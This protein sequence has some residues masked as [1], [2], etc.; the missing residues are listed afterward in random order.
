MFSVQQLF[1]TH[2]GLSSFA[3][4]LIF[5]NLLI[6]AGRCMLGFTYYIL[7]ARNKGQ[8]ATYLDV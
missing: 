2:L 3:F 4:A 5:I 1:G 8:F 7:Y 6:M